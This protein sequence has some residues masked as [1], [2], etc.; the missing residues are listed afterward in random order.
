V[1]A[2]QGLW[3]WLGRVTLKLTLTSW[4]ILE[5]YA[6]MQ[7]VNKML[8]KIIDVCFA[9]LLGLMLAGGALAYF[10]VLVK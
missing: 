2:S 1:F 7:R 9:V 4:V 8:D 10:D 6:T 3:W 5:L